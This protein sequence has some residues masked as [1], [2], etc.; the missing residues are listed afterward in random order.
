MAWVVF[1]SSPPAVPVGLRLGSFGRS[2]GSRCILGNVPNGGFP[3][4]G[5]LVVAEGGRATVADILLRM[6]IWISFPINLG[7]AYVLARPNSWF[8]QQIG[9]PVQVEPLYAGLSVGGAARLR[10]CLAGLAAQPYAALASLG[11]V[12]QARLFRHRPDP[13]AGGERIDAAHRLRRWRSTARPPLAAMA[14]GI[15]PVGL[16]RILLRNCLFR[17]LGSVSQILDSVGRKILFI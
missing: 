1:A 3:N 4:A 9:L 6:S 16:L 8:G 14:E 10:L 17:Q 2:F 13:M 7:M 5:A 15:A 12:E 11:C